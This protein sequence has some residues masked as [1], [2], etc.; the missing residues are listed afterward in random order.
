MEQAQWRRGGSVKSIGDILRR[1]TLGVAPASAARSSDGSVERVRT[2][3]APR[4]P[5]LDRL[6]PDRAVDRLLVVA[7]FNNL[8]RN[9]RLRW[10]RLLAQRLGRSAPDCVAALMADLIADG[11][12]A[13]VGA[14]LRYRLDAIAHGRSQDAWSAQAPQ[15]VV[16]AVRRAF[17]GSNTV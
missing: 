8:N 5:M 9:A 4:L 2:S 10:S 13:C 16:E 6:P 7:D 15:D 14:C 12:A 11:S 17:L 1:F 3:L